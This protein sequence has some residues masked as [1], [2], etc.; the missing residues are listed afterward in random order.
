MR[1]SSSSGPSC[2]CTDLNPESLR[3]AE[4][5][6]YPI[7]RV[8]VYAQ[9]SAGER[10]PFARR[11]LR[12]MEAWSSIAGCVARTF[13]DHCLA[14]DAVFAEV[15]LISCRNVLIYFDRELQDRAIGLFTRAG[16]SGILRARLARTARRIQVSR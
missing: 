12:H 7:D 5:G 9:L 14:T 8:A 16:A 11:L 10:R 4:A 6:V 3:A 15:H 1:R 2:A 13:S